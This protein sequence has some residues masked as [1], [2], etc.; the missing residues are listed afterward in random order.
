MGLPS[1]MQQ[2]AGVS[3]SGPSTSAHDREESTAVVTPA[4][5]AADA[6]SIDTSANLPA[7]MRQIA[8]MTAPAAVGES[9]GTQNAGDG[10]GLGAAEAHTATTEERLVR[11]SSPTTLHSTEK[12]VMQDRAHSEELPA[13][14]RQVTR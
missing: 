3:G 8:A 9:T 1:W 10:H 6:A 13:W 11:K 14:L 4:R 12:Q 5:H 7:W 2:L